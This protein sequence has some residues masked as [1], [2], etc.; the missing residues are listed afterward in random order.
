M[1]QPSGL[2]MCRF[3]TNYHRGLFKSSMLQELV[4]LLSAKEDAAGMIRLRAP[5]GSPSKGHSVTQ[6]GMV[7]CAPPETD[8]VEIIKRMHEAI[9]EK[10]VMNH[11]IL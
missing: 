4:K 11:G 1:H 2:E 9:F 8:Y 3:L 7:F 6:A 10:L 5:P